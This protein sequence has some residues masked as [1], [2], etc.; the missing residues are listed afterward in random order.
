MKAEP[1]RQE[2][3][4]AKRYDPFIFRQNK[5]GESSVSCP[6]TNGLL[7]KEIFQLCQAKTTELARD[8]HSKAIAAMWFGAC[9]KNCFDEDNFQPD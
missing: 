2:E 4:N 8:G 7:I 9:L 5:K 1:K 6:D 3:M